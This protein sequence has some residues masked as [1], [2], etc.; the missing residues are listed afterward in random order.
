MSLLLD[1]LARVQ[2]RIATAAERAGRSADEVKLIAVTKY[3]DATVA[4]QLFEAGCRDLGE[5]R[6]QEL[7]AKAAA[8]DPHADAPHIWLAMFH[9]EAGRNREALREINLARRAKPDRSF[10][11]F[12]YGQVTSAMKK[13]KRK[14]ADGKTK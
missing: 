11:N 10:T 3:V 14:P 12:V 5:A 4:R 8:I 7:L 2:Q 1:N 6:P 9:L 13:G